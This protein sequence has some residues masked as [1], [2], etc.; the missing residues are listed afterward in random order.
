MPRDPRQ[1]IEGRAGSE[2]I[3]WAGDNQ[4]QVV[5]R[6]EEEGDHSHHSMLPCQL[7]RAK[8]RN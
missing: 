3:G 8:L 5:H 7:R 2:R 1:S 6:Q 4:E